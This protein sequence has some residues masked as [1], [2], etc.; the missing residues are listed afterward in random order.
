MLKTEKAIRDILKM[1]YVAF[2]HHDENNIVK[3]SAEEG[4]GAAD[5]WGEFS[6]G[7]PEIH[8]KLEAYADK[9]GLYWEWVNPGCIA[10]YPG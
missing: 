8:P 9:H 1:G 4:D 5:Y 2:H 10:L 7:D 6:G 3:V